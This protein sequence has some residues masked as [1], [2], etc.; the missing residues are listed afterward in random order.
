MFQ[1]RVY[2]QIIMLNANHTVLKEATKPDPTLIS[3]VNVLYQ[4]YCTDPLRSQ[5][6]F[7]VNTDLDFMPLA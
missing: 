3:N 2:Y 6:A 7:S 4:L 1:E 5:P